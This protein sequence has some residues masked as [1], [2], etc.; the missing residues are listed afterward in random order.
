MAARARRA[1]RSRCCV[2]WRI[3]TR[4][5]GSPLVWL[6]T[7][8]VTALAIWWGPPLRYRIGEVYPHDLRARVD[9][10]VINHVELINQERQRDGVHEDVG[11]TERPVFEKYPRGMLLVPRGEPILERQFDLLKEEHRRLPRRLDLE[12]PVVSR[13][14]ACF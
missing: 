3:G 12:G 11:Y 6:T 2:N 4:C 1:R 10:T 13:H 5:C 14:F 9:F 8:L 7:V